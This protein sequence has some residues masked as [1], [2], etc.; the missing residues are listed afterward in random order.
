M[1]A[2]SNEPNELLTKTQVRRAEVRNFRNIERLDLEP[3]PRVNVICGENGQGKTSL[4]EALY[5]LATARS[6]RTEKL[7]A[8]LTHGKTQ[9]N[10]TGVICDDAYDREQ[11]VTIQKKTRTATIDGKKP[12]RLS[13]YAV[14]TP[15]V[16]FHPGD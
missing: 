13:D 2:Q 4:I 14:R 6:F 8:L 1:Q 15:V 11:C 16:V 12:T 5:F 7:G 9:G 10:V 3:C